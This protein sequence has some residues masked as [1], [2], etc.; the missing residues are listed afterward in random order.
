M[1]SSILL[2]LEVAA[3]ATVLAAVAGVG[4]GYLLSRRRHRGW[5]AV[6]ILFTLPMVFPPTLTGY[7][8]VLLFGRHGPIGGPLFE[9]TGLQLTFHPAGAVL[10][11]AVVSFP[12]MLLSARAAL[13]SV[14]PDLEKAA[15]TLGRSRWA[16]AWRITL[17]LAWRGLAVGAVLTFAR[18]LG[19]FGATLMM[20]GNQPTMPLAIYRAWMSGGTAA[21]TGFVVAHTLLAIGVL[22]L[23]LFVGRRY[24]R[25]FSRG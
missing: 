3:I 11:A 22:A 7:Y 20:A 25:A 17:P 16:V 21:A 24:G 8:L 13:E 9:L 14:D 12:L 4:L 6:E 5:L 10:A 18:A 15:Y 2:S 19:E 1:L 23:A